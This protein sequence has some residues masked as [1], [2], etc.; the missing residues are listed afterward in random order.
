MASYNHGYRTL[1]SNYH[2]KSTLQSKPANASAL[3]TNV[4]CYLINLNLPAANM[5]KLSNK[6]PTTP[7]S[8]SV[9][10]RVEP[11]SPHCAQAR[12]LRRPPIRSVGRGEWVRRCRIQA[13]YVCWENVQRTRAQQKKKSGKFAKVCVQETHRECG[14]ERMNAN[15]E[16]RETIKIDET[17]PPGCVPWL[18]AIA[19]RYC[20]SRAHTHT[21]GDK[22]TR[23]RTKLCTFITG[24]EKC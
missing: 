7:P 3:N 13:G 16:R 20:T 12:G 19:T 4:K 9:C 2:L 15:E 1:A 10:T 23:A 6:F 22:R 18:A 5:E 11:I 8:R 17:L 24:H 21:L 14:S